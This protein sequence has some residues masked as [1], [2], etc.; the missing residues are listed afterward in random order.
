MR[1]KHSLTNTNLIFFSQEILFLLIDESSSQKLMFRLENLKFFY[2]K[3][4]GL[5]PDS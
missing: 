1:E 5:D 3:D 4:V 2:L